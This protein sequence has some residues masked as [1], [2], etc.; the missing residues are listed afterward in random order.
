MSEL[1]LCGYPCLVVALKLKKALMCWKCG[2][3]LFLAVKKR[4]KGAGYYARSRCEDLNGGRRAEE[5]KHREF[6]PSGG[7]QDSAASCPLVGS[8]WLAA[9]RRTRVT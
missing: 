2:Q 5:G 7:C 3:L 8:A 9:A 4:E 6:G 1:I